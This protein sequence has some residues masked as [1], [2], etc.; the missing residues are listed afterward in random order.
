M[1]CFGGCRKRKIQSTV[2]NNVSVSPPKESG[3]EMTKARLKD[4]GQS[5][6]SSKLIIAIDF[7]TTFTGVAYYSSSKT[8]P[9][10]VPDLLNSDVPTN[11]TVIRNWPSQDGQYVE[12][13]P[14]VVTYST[15]PMTWGGS[16]KPR[17]EK[18]ANFK[19]GLEPEI[20]RYY[21]RDGSDTSMRFTTPEGV[22][23]K[24]VE[25]TADYLTCVLRYVH[26]ACFPAQFG[27]DFLSKRQMDYI[28]TV[29][30]IWSDR[31]KSLTRQA[32]VK[33]GIPEDRLVLVTEP[34]AAALYCA[35]TCA[36]VDLDDGDRFLI[37][38]A[39]G[40]TVV[41]HELNIS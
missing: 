29:P 27:A 7:G 10:A 15:K 13:T 20:E 5:S 17:H 6:S 16:V 11:I 33:A 35:T 4:P 36:E 32:T 41:S 40:G 3:M 28:I 25:I 18:I 2:F 9:A 21:S 39:G 1:G 37:C 30:A 34:E 31:A 12:K 8:L 23:K 19:L 14:T 26:E 24:P 38:D 22:N